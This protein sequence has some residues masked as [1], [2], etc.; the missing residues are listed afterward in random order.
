MPGC[1]SH[2]LVFVAVLSNALPTLAFAESSHERFQMNR[3]IRVEQND[4][5]GDLTCLNCSVYIRGEVAGDIFALNGRVVVEQGAQVSGD[6]ATLLG[7]VRLDDGAK[8][9]GDVAAIGGTVRRSPQ[10]TIAGD[11]SSMA[12]AGWVILAFLVPLLVVA[13]FVALIVWLI[14]RARR[15]PPLTASPVQ[16]V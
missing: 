9:A 15:P 5:T 4:K 2:V 14:R 10:A 1:R 13:G 11:V 8:I 7:D 3:D 16:R 12:G 6:V